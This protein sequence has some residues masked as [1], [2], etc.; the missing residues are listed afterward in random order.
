MVE[1]EGAGEKRT[2]KPAQMIASAL[3]AVTAAFLGSTLGVEGTVLGAGRAGVRTT[4]GSEVYL[5]SLRRTR[6]AAR[7]TKEV[8]APADTRLRQETRLVEPP[9]K[10]PANP[11]IRPNPAMPA[12]PLIRPNPAMPANPLARPNPAMP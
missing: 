9:P 4:V 1:K 2:F 12:N 10:G 3:A 5:R 6:A 11:L 7:K 8:L